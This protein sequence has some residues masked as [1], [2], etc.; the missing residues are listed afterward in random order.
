MGL[1]HART[2]TFSLSV[3]EKMLEIITWDVD[4]TNQK[5]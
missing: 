4:L 2:I 1:H 5:K 3:N